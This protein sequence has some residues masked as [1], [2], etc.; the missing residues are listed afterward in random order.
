VV[1]GSAGAVADQA[2][3][4]TYLAI[5]SPSGLFLIDCGDSPVT[6]LQRAGL[7]IDRLRGVIVTHFHPDHVATLPDLAVS[8]WL[9]G[10]SRPLPIYGLPDVTD[11][12]G[13]MMRL[14]RSDQWPGFYG[15]PDHSV[16]EVQGA[17]VLETDDIRITSAPTTHTVP[18]MGLRIENKATGGIVAYSSDT[19]P[20]EELAELSRG[21]SILFHEATG[22][23][24]G[25]SS[26]AQ[27]GEIGRRARA[28]RLILIHYPPDPARRP[29]WVSAACEAFGG[30]VELARDYD[31][32]KF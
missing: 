27:A 18:S 4:H 22:D 16:A 23:V 2:H 25:H 3:G 7:G 15:L 14:Y 12:F 8:A 28:A 9:L 30:P 24:A 19:E 1:L 11:R 31:Q 26:A 13:A 6:R 21:A 32:Y 20:C 17:E 10:R 29:N 5:D